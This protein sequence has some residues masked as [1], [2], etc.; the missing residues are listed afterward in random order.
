MILSYLAG[1]YDHLDTSNSKIHPLFQILYTDS[2]WWK[3]SGIVACK[4]SRAGAGAAG[5][6][7]GVHLDCRMGWKYEITE[8]NSI[9]QDP[10]IDCLPREED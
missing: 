9:N 1:R 10:H 6:G 4:N 7:A 2:G 5:G 3:N 8:L